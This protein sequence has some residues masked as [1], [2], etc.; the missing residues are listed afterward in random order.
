MKANH[1]ELGDLTSID[2]DVL[3]PKR[4]TLERSNSWPGA[5]TQRTDFVFPIV[6][7]DDLRLA[8]AAHE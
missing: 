1:V 6:D 4:E 7:D 8:V 2:V 5:S 3:H